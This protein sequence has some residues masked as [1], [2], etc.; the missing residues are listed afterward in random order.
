MDVID[1]IIDKIKLNK[2]DVYLP[3]LTELKDFKYNKHHVKSSGAMGD[4]YKYTAGYTIGDFKFDYEHLTSDGMIA[5]GSCKITF[6]NITSLY[7]K[8]NVFT[9]GTIN[10]DIFDIF[11]EKYKLE[12]VQAVVLIDILNSF[13]LGEVICPMENNQTGLRHINELL[14]FIH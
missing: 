13:T 14:K 6:N 1:D 10:Y 5:Y 11:A 12:K 2:R 4:C 9:G 3:V 8:S 7:L